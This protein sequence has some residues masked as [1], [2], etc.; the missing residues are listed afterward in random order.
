MKGA[1]SD[2]L[3]I[4]V[5]TFL[6]WK[7]GCE[8][9]FPGVSEP[10]EGG[11]CEWEVIF[12]HPQ[13]T[14]WCLI[15]VFVPEITTFF[16]SP[17]FVAEVVLEDLLPCFRSLVMDLD[18]FF[19]F[20]AWR[21]NPSFRMIYYHGPEPCAPRNG[22]ANIL[23]HSPSLS[24]FIQPSPSIKSFFLCLVY[25]KWNSQNP[26]ITAKFSFGLPST[27]SLLTSWPLKNAKERYI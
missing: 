14:G 10:C 19:G 11:F 8:V 27:C 23:Q 1:G 16:S 6:K 18:A 15:T 22:F 12:F 7:E 9:Y 2:R 3:V 21:I 5:L 26:S 17:S 25:S 4:L 13:W 20:L 24:L